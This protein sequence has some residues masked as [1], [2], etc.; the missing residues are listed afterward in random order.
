MICVNPTASETRGVFQM[1]SDASADADTVLI[2]KK[3]AVV[4][5]SKGSAPSLPTPQA[6]VLSL[7]PSLPPSVCPNPLVLRRPW[8]VVRQTTPAH[9]QGAIT[10]IKFVWVAAGAQ[11]TL[12]VSRSGEVYCWGA[13]QYGQLGLGDLEERAT[14]HAILHK[15]TRSKIARV[16]AGARHSLALTEGGDLFSWGGNECGQLGYENK[17]GGAPLDSGGEQGTAPRQRSA[18]DC[19]VQARRRWTVDDQTSGDTVDP[20]WLV[21]YYSVGNLVCQSTNKCV[22][23]LDNRLQY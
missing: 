23:S 7:Q 18:C 17:V 5:V 14:P 10:G 13:N 19:R 11:H 9:L 4:E 22:R 8:Q 6:L 16:A 3:T 20:A 1:Q 15:F 12:A 21:F 2:I